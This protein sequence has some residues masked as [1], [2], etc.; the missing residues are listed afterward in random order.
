MRSVAV[1]TLGCKVN[2]YDSQAL[3]AQF[4]QEGY[5]VVD[6][7]DFATVYV[8]NT[9]CVTNL[10]DKKSRQ[11]IGRARQK[12]P[13]AIVVAMG[14]ASQSD[15]QKYT[16][17]DVDIIAGTT[18]RAKILDYINE[19]NGTQIVAVKSDILQEKTF[20]VQAGEFESNRT[21]AFLKI[22][23][24]CSNFCSYCVIPYAR[25]G[26]RSRNF[27]DLMAQAHA[28]ADAGYK[29]IV[30]AGIHVASYGKDLQEYG[31]VDVL[32][33]IAKIPKIARV[34]LS[35]VE[36]MAI[37]AEFC[38][39]MSA[40][41]KFCNHLHL[42]LQ[43]GSNAVLEAMKRR[44]DTYAFERSVEDLRT[45]SPDIN[46]TT[47]LIAGFPGESDAEHQKSLD[48]A[49]KIGF[50]K[51]H[52]FPFAPKEKTAA[53]KMQN[54]IAKNIKQNRAKELLALSDELEK[55][56][57]EKFIGKT[58][59]V[60]IEESNKN[61]YA[62]G[63]T[64]NYIDLRFENCNA[65]LENEIVDVEVISISKGGMVGLLKK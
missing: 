4:A 9:C 7:R 42:S 60:L 14:C 47:D 38:D 54:Q 58:M 45:A 23:D 64:M 33:K 18:E 65:E 46:I 15:S 13:Q 17:L 21:R 27:D 20:E 22:Q 35:S 53:A 6:F 56:Y 10:A 26:S 37:T 40:N 34:R 43:S 39:F 48:F 25:G 24:G 19:Y 44:Y 41:P 59:P 30:V 52:V 49:K 5:E 16:K 12:N 62:I 2:S 31:L 61:N 36:P 29:E 8:V 51:L 1:A 63:K 57:Y 50:S 28:F 3:L 32:A 55:K 11:I